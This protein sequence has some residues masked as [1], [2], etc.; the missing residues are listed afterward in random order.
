MEKLAAR[1][2]FL[3]TKAISLKCTIGSVS[4]CTYARALE[5]FKNRLSG[6]QNADVQG[7]CNLLE[8]G[9]G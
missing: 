6:W 7:M 5:I 2:H 4:V 1:S 9:I 3:T 8:V